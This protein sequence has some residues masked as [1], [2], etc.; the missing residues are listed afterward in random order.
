MM[1]IKFLNYDNKQKNFDSM[2]NIEKERKL[3][4]RKAKV[5]NEIEEKQMEAYNNDYEKVV[6]NIKLT[7]NIDKDEYKNMKET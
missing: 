1:D 3:Q 4:S 5:L 6:E 2:K 7:E